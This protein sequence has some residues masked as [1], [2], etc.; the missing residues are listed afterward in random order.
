MPDNTIIPVAAKRKF[1]FN[2]MVLPDPDPAMTPQKVCEFHS[3]LHAELTNATVKGPTRNA[4][5]CDEYQL[6]PQIG[7]YR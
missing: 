3:L 1:V 7:T 6:T 2:G 5:G 4:D